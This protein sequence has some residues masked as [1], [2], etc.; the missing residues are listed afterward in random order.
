MHKARI[1]LRFF[2]VLFLLFV[3]FA[4]EPAFG[5]EPKVEWANLGSCEWAIDSGS[6]LIRPSEGSPEGLLGEWDTGNAPWKEHSQEIHSVIFSGR[7]RVDS[8]GQDELV[9][10]TLGALPALEVLDLRG[11]DNSAQNAHSKDLRDQWA[12]LEKVIVGPYTNLGTG[13]SNSIREPNGVGFRDGFWLSSKTNI[14]Y[15]EHAIPQLCDETFLYIGKDEVLE[16]FYAYDGIQWGVF[17]GALIVQPNEDNLE[18]RCRLDAWGSADRYPWHRLR[19]AVASIDIRRSVSFDYLG[20]AFADCPSLEKVDLS[21]L[22]ASEVRD[23]SYL[24]EGCGKLVSF[25]FAGLDFSHVE[26]MS[27]AFYNCHDL[28]EVLFNGVNLSSVQDFS[29]LFG[30][31]SSLNAVDLENVDTSSAADFDFMFSGCEEL[32]TLD[33]SMLDV[34]NVTSMASLF[35]GCSSLES[36]VL[37]NDV[38]DRLQDMGYLFDGCSSLE[39]VDLTSFSAATVTD[40]SGLFRGCASL[41]KI[42]LTPFSKNPIFQMRDF[43]SG[44]SNLQS[45]DLLQLEL[46]NVQDMDFAFYDCSSLESIS[47]EGSTFSDLKSAVSTFEKCTSL[48]QVNFR[49]ISAPAL[50]SFESTFEGCTSLGSVDLSGADI[51]SIQTTRNMFEGCSALASVQLGSLDLPDL[52][53]MGGM[54]AHCSALIGVD[55]SGLTLG[56]VDSMRTIFYECENLDNI[57]LAGLELSSATDLCAAFSGCSKL[58]RADVSGL[59]LSSLV[60]SSSMFEGCI[61][62]EHVSFC[63]TI[64]PRLG[65]VSQMFKGCASLTVL[66][67]SGFEAD[68]LTDARFLFYGCSSLPYLD[69]SGFNTT[70]ANNLDDIF[71][72]CRNMRH[73]KVGASFSFTGLDGSRCRLPYY[74]EQGVYTGSWVDLISMR[75][76]DGNSVTDRIDADYYALRPFESTVLGCEPSDKA[77]T[78]KGIELTISTALEENK[79]Y[80]CVYRDNV[81]VGVASCEVFGLGQYAGHYSKYQ[82]NIVKAN[83]DRPEISVLNASYGQKL[84][85]L[86]LPDGYAWDVVDQDTLVGD[87]GVHVYRATYTPADTDNYNVILDIPVEVVVTRALDT[88]LFEIDLS[89]EVYSGNPIVKRI[90]SVLSQQ[91]DYDVEYRSNINAGAATIVITGKGY[92]HGRLEFSFVIE[93]ANPSYDI[94]DNVQLVLGQALNSIALPDGFSWQDDG[95]F[96]PTELGTITRLV[97]FVPEDTNNYH[98]IRD[99]PIAIN[100]VEARVIPVPAV[101]SLVYCGEK[102]VPKVPASDDYV[103]LENAGGLDVGS[104]HVTVG[105]TDPAATCWP[106]G[107]RSDII[108]SYQVLPAAMAAVEA[109]PLPP[110][111]YSGTDIEPSLSLTYFDHALQLG[112]D[113]SVSYRSNVDAGVGYV[114][115]AGLGNYTGVRELPFEITPLDFSTSARVSDIPTQLYQGVPVEPEVELA[116]DGTVLVRE[117]DFVAFYEANEAPGT[118]TVILRGKGNYTGEIRVPFEIRLPERPSNYGVLIDQGSCGAG[119]TWEVY[120]SGLLVIDGAGKMDFSRSNDSPWK[121]RHGKSIRGA[122]VGD[123]ITFICNFAFSGMPNCQIILFKGPQTPGYQKFFAQYAWSGLDTSLCEIFHAPGDETWSDDGY[124]AWIPSMFDID[125]ASLADI[126]RCGADAIWVLRSNGTLEISG[127]GLVDESMS[128]DNIKAIKN[129]EVLDGITGITVSSPFVS[130]FTPAPVRSV[131]IADSVTSLPERFLSDLAELEE[132]TLPA[133]LETIPEYLCDGCTSLGSIEI[134][135]GCASI[136]ERAFQGCSSLKSIVLPD[137][138][139]SLGKYAF[140]R[141]TSLE[142]VSAGNKLA[143]IDEYA[144]S[145]SVQLQN[146]ASGIAVKEIKKSAFEGCSSFKPVLAEGVEIIRENAFKNCASVDVLEIPA[147]VEQLD[148]ESINFPVSRIDFMGELPELALAYSGGDTK[149]THRSGDATWNSVDK[150][151]FDNIGK[152]TW[153]TRDA[154]GQLRE[155]DYISPYDST[156]LSL[157][158][159]STAGT[160]SDR[161]THAFKFTVDNPGKVKLSCLLWRDSTCTHQSFSVSL[162]S[163]AGNKGKVVGRWLWDHSDPDFITIDA[164]LEQGDYYLEVFYFT[165]HKGQSGSISVSFGYPNEFSDVNSSTPHNGHIQ[166]LA[167]RGISEGW[168]NHDGTYSFRP[169]AIV[170][171]ADMA[172]FLYRLAGEPAFDEASAPRFSDVN[173]STP[174]R[175]AILWLA[176]QGI[177]KGWDNGDGTFSFRPYANVARADMAA[178]LYRLAGSPEFDESSVTAFRDVDASTPHREAILWL[179][180]SGVSKGWDEGGGAYSF[181]PY[182]EVAR[183]DMA[184]FLHRMDENGLVDKG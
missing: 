14:A 5:V 177:S 143:L 183:C 20:H 119:V 67:F 114:V 94:P 101:S 30:G 103:V 41:R 24:F 127:S 161:W 73:V 120:D 124:E 149:A 55:L 77:Y 167:R 51:R 137:N 130:L 132:V 169:Y 68:G 128:Y 65:D 10:T 36:V 107:S 89:G 156:V 26:K 145:G 11:Y 52:R 181:R 105:L 31:C 18:G 138:L 134:P 69:L 142:T 97:Q 96:V 92:Y 1:V 66:D 180:S 139:V 102:Q 100:V 154:G 57:S 47:F 70:K 27:C 115:V 75:V 59:D 15:D 62:L 176:S 91:A 122:I 178:F 42:D 3:S 106:D 81:Q 44:C 162:K 133:K 16:Q 135:S 48:L 95:G 86:P 78:G 82:F 153:F 88:T 63:N 53:D 29:M 38:S 109:V 8:D 110:A 46:S 60:D 108:V 61:S 117:T 17:S 39:Q 7:V 151:S 174:H 168:D 45:V 25:D 6:L 116:V 49:G 35:S 58:H 126:D 22:D 152:V 173:S 104:Y 9:W 184:A 129:V 175:K 165:S 43:A 93:K 28:K 71:G 79:D 140:S 157:D 54:F 21:G 64:A 150:Y 111:E 179:A 80:R 146:F 19:D 87:P 32:K 131:V 83:P 12:S 33:V 112:V 170:A 125:W 72:Y 160:L 37:F 159:S 74:D 163:C 90:D 84:L 56:S 13:W 155:D 148:M 98:T 171:R 144:F 4:S 76:V 23:A 99:I 123:G 158:A 136:G 2:P 147:S 121:V 166:W 113:Y 164:N 40:I 141:C 172:A 34:S 118:G 85:E 182:L 50:L